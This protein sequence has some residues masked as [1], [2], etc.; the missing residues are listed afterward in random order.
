MIDRRLFL[1]GSSA[2]VLGAAGGA[3]ARA[4][5]TVTTQLQWI[6]DVQNAGWWV[7]D[8]NGYFR[9]AGIEATMLAGGPNLASVEAIV[10][11]GR[12]DIGIDQLERV[13]DANNQGEDFVIFA[14]LYQQDPAALLSL[15]KN[16][17]RSAHDILGKRIGLQQGAQLY[18]DAIM[19]VN[20]LP[21]T[22]T[23]VVV[24]FDPQ[25]LVEGAC[26]AYLCFVTNQPLTLASRGIP[27]I[28]A[29]FDQ[30]GYETYS[31]ALF[32]TRD[33][34]K[35]NRATLV[36]FVRA[37]QRGWAANAQ[38]PALAAHL[39]TTVYGASLGL[40]EKQQLAVNRAQIPLM[41]SAA[42]RAH[43][44]MWIDTARVT[45][46][47]YTTLRATGRTKLPPVDQLIDMSVLR[48]A[49]LGH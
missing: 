35:K 41:E 18:I 30:L 3:P 12:A 14:A 40:D 7:A 16:P 34:L 17:V 38:N 47:I 44:R 13:I 32:C 28:T 48:D 31:D 9:D 2:A 37:L 22:Y 27:A 45:G 5:D 6:K 39:A 10:A 49:T 26:D 4:A 1:A 29:T 36:R 11:A 25:P 33:Y 8:A 21:P 42:T 46:P 24:G 23:D 19:K 43:G 15:P 20:H